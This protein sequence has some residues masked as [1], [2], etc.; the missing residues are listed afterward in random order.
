MTR[1]QETRSS[2]CRSIFKDISKTE[3]SKILSKIY[4]KSTGNLRTPQD[5]HSREDRKSVLIRFL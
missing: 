4:S 3:R 1:L 2:P 5:S